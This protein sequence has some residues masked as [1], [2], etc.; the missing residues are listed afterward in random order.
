MKFQGVVTP[1]GITT[2]LCG[3]YVGRVHDSNMLKR[4]KLQD[5]LRDRLD[6]TLAG[7]PKYKI[8]GDSAYAESDVLLRAY[9]S[10]MNQ[11]MNGMLIINL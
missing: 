3:P 5:Q 11:Y 8:Y 1:D 10:G 4:S 6:W 7:R 9:K 2:I